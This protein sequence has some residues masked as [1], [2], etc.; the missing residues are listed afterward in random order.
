MSPP[1][2]G[3][4]HQCWPSTWLGRVH[5]SAGLRPRELPVAWVAPRVPGDES[6]LRFMSQAKELLDDVVAYE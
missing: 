6:S 4:K 5:E 1:M 2:T 3:T